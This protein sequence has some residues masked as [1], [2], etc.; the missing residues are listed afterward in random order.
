MNRNVIK[1]IIVGLA[2]SLLGPNFVSAQTG[3]TLEITSLSRTTQNAGNNVEVTFRAEGFTADQTATLW[4]VD[5][6]THTAIQEIIAIDVPVREGANTLTFTIPFSWTYPGYFHVQLIA[7]ILNAEG[8]I[9]KQVS[10]LSPDTL[11]VRSAVI[12]PYGRTVI[13]KSYQRS[14]VT[15]TTTD[16]IEAQYFKIYLSNEITGYLQLLDDQVDPS[17]GRY[18]WTIPDVSGG[19]FRLLIQGFIPIEEEGSIWE[20]PAEITQSE[21]IFIE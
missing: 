14:W 8:Q 7:T 18:L 10:S 12:W 20:D 19:N 21:K 15:W 6:A 4:L 16:V 1:S 5:R 13:N 11:R 17:L 2:V 3:Q 9:S